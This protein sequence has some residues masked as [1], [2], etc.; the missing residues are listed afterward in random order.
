MTLSQ[1]YFKRILLF[2]RFYLTLSTYQLVMSARKIAIA[3]AIVHVLAC[4]QIVRCEGYTYTSSSTYTSISGSGSVSASA[5][6]TASVSTG[7]SGPREICFLKDLFVDSQGNPQIVSEDELLQALKQRLEGRNDALELVSDLCE[8]YM[9][10]TVEPGAA[11]VLHF[12][13][14][15]WMPEVTKYLLFTIGMDP[16]AKNADNEPVLFMVFGPLLTTVS[17][18]YQ[19]VTFEMIDILLQACADPS[20]GFS[21]GGV[22]SY[23]V[24]HIAAFDGKTDI[25]QKFAAKGTNFQVVD[26]RGYNPIH[27]AA[28]CDFRRSFDPWAKA[29][30]IFLIEQGVDVFALTNAGESA[31]DLVDQTTCPETYEYLKSLGL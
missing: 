18:N 24:I 1:I 19:D 21:Y 7:G 17:G 2:S 22:D 8:E 23:T 14:V 3:V 13:A 25:L 31:L 11:T 26:S 20:I 12:A 9:R 30:I 29:T 4:L 15:Q 16:N 5:S 28:R 6:A 27:S 10:N